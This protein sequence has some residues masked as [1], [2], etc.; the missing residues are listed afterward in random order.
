M[1]RCHSEK[2]AKKREQKEITHKLATEIPSNESLDFPHTSTVYVESATQTDPS[3]WIEKFNLP[4][5][6]G[7]YSQPDPRNQ[8][9]VIEAFPKEIAK[10][11]FQSTPESSPK[12]K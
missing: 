9:R 10:P 3:P 7:S 11:E 2:T 6:Q 5:T 4:C 8:D 1:L 12:T